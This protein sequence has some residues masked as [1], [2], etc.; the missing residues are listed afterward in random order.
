MSG[1]RFWLKFFLLALTLTM[2]SCGGTNP[3]TTNQIATGTNSNTAANRTIAANQATVANQT[4]IANQTVVATPSPTPKKEGV[5]SLEAGLV[6]QSGD[7]KPVA[8]TTFYLLDESAVKLMRQA[9]VK[10]SG[11]EKSDVSIAG[12]YGIS[13][14]Y[15]N[16]PNASRANELIKKH[17]IQSVTTDFG[18]KA[19]FNPV[20][21]GK[22]Y[23]FGISS[24]PKG[25]AIWDMKVDLNSAETSVTLDQNNAVVA[26]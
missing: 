19:K 13:S 9:G 17:S 22:Y 1:K 14:K 4:V 7:I 12:A 5:V 15:S 26:L 21:Q 25:F 23:L 8:R 24:T 16:N 3:N 20:P 11:G 10:S 6:F 18:G 2:F